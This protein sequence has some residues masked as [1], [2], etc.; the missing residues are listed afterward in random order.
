MQAPPSVSIAAPVN[1]ASYVQGRTLDSSFTCSDG[2]GGPGIASCAD[3]NGRGPGAAIDTSTTGQLSVTA[4]STDGLTG[5]ATVT[6]TVTAPIPRLSRLQLK[7]RSFQAATKGK[8]I[9]DRIENGT[10]ITYRD[11]L[12]AHTTL[13][14]YHELR[15][16][17][18]G[19]KCAATH[20][21]KQ[22]AN[23]KACTRLILIG[24]FKR[25]DNIGTNR[26]RFTGPGSGR[27][28]PKPGQL[29]APGNRQPR[30]RS[31]AARSAHRSRS[32]HRRRRAFDPDH[33][34]DCDAPGQT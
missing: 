10:T 3:Q 13:R 32:W 5:S 21:H 33:D 29:R 30:R 14:V 31:K 17:K 26:L 9:I 22:Q 27:P 23:G 34:G 16:V 28:R 2:A 11:T 12:A 25:H 7:P 6:Y 20:G 18:R 19:G 8:A 1:G 4:T 24:S 15:G